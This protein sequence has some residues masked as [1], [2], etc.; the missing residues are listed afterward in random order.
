MKNS[1]T[2]TIYQFSYLRVAACIAIITLHTVYAANEYFAPTLSESQNLF[3]RMVENCMM[4]AVPC[5]L[6]VTGA[7]L[8]NRKKEITFK[9]LFGKY[10]L[11]IVAALLVFSMVFR[12]FDIIMD[13][14]NVSTFSV[15]QGFQ[16]FF[17]DMSWGHLWYL[18]LLIGLYLL[19]PFY[20]KIAD[21][22]TKKELCYLLVLYVVFLSL[23]PG[24]GM[25]GIECGFYICVSLIYPLYLFCGH[26]LHEHILNINKGLAWCLLV[27][28]TGLILFL[29]KVRWDTGFEAMDTLWGYSSILVILQTTGMFAVME[30]IKADK[31]PRLNIVMEKLDECSFGVY[32]I[33]MIFVRLILRYGNFN[34]YENGGVPTF[35]A[36]IAGIF[37]A[38]YA[39]TWVLRKIPGVARI[40]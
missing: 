8:L 22:S 5:F 7:L 3:S 10:I 33:H 29:T 4:W 37:I 31:M 14:E 9:K 24:L 17:A 16:E 2:K 21:H 1:S 23:L 35:I 28:S 27:V 15:L 13:K 39:I 36:L 34:P 11:R 18:Y 38:S 40:L 20:K 26:M 6:M 12:I 25:W 19:L 32:L 30:T